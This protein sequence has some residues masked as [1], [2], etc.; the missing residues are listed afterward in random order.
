MLTMIP[1]TKT[2]TDTDSKHDINTI[3]YYMIPDDGIWH[4]CS[5]D[6]PLLCSVLRAPQ[7]VPQGSGRCQHHAAWFSFMPEFCI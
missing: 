3:L 7:C 5:G 2:N 4:D 6:R 1:N